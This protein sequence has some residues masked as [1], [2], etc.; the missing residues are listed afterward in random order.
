MWRQWIGLPH[1]FRADPRDGIGADCL[2]MVWAALDQSTASHPAFNP[3][4]LDM[5]EAG[6]HD[7]LIAAYKSLTM[8]LA[9]PEEH[10]VTLFSTERTIGIGIVVDDGLLHVH[11]KRG[12]QWLPIARCK[13]LEFR[14]FA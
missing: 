2:L 14:K 13:T 7:E 1:R 8:P 3:A 11:H 6:D 5:A 4:W 9:A 12:V 10:A